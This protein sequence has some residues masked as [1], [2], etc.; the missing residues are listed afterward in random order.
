MKVVINVKM[1]ILYLWLHKASVKIDTV[2]PVTWAL[3][4]VIHSFP[5]RE[6][7]CREADS[8]KHFMQGTE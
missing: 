5:Q 1:T 6:G 3:F 4:Y 8:Q 7:V 2:Y